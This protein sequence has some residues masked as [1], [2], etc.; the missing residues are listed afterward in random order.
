M[1]LARKMAAVGQQATAA[2]E[3]DKITNLRTGVSF[4]GKIVP[5]EDI[6]MNSEL[7][8]DPRASATVYTLDRSVLAG[9]NA[10]DTWQALGSKFTVL[11]G[12]AADNPA[13]LHLAFHVMKTEA[14]DQQ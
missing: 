6:T 5:I 14:C 3:E 1:S 7:G 8:L 10:L 4:M 2:F 13:S 9:T 12:K 11:P